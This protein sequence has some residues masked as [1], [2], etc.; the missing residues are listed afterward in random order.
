MSCTAETIGGSTVAALIVLKRLHFLSH[1]EPFP[2]PVF[3]RC[4]RAGAYGQVSFHSDQ[5]TQTKQ[6]ILWWISQK[7]TNCISPLNNINKYRAKLM[8]TTNK[9]CFLYCDIIFYDNKLNFPS[10]FPLLKCIQ[11]IFWI[12]IIL[13][14]D[15]HYCNAI[16]VLE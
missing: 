1:H 8:F 16:F 4:T 5:N 6:G 10:T 12:F 9:S 7:H 13:Y 11:I 2:V 3:I 15:S 14:V